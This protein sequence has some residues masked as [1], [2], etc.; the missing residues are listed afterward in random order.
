MGAPVYVGND[1]DGND[2]WSSH[3]ETLIQWLCDGYRARFNQH[4][5]QRK[6]TVWTDDPNSPGTRIPLRDADGEKVLAP[7]GDTEP[8]AKL[9]DTE[10]RETF[11]F[12]A[13]LPMQVLQHPERV[14]NTE[15]WSVIKRR[16]TLAA[17]RIPAGAMP[18]FRSR[19][20]GDCRFGVWFNG[21]KNAVA[22]RV[23]RSSGVLVITGMNPADKR[24]GKPARWSLRI[25]FRQTA[26]LRAYTSVEV[27]WATKRLVFISPPPE[28]EHASTGKLVG[29][30]RGVANAV[31]TSSG[32]L[33]QMPDTAGAERARKRHQQAMARSN[34]VAEAEGR[35]WRASNRR[36]RHRGLA[37]KHSRR[38]ANVR[39]EFVEQTSHRLIRDH[40]LVALEALDVRAMTRAPKPVPDPNKPGAWLSNGAAAKRGLNR[41]I[42][43]SGWTMLAERLRQ[44]G[45]QAGVPVVF[46]DPKH[47][48]Q[49]CSECGHIA[50]ENRE[51]QAIFRCVACG[52][53]E[54]ADINAARNILARATTGWTSP[55]GRRSQSGVGDADTAISREPRTPAL[56]SGPTGIPRL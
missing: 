20:R 30:D 17:K 54:H 7:L 38:I 52:Y 9:R 51:S 55:A 16:R 15:W 46:V 50:P 27:N 1:A 40:D 48:S 34:R 31:V 47:T 41:G 11:P 26:E 33:I 35:D 44:K 53:T 5:A 56:A 28:R 3:P 39:K 24:Q 14:E 13:A 10:A 23:S 18:R 19:K 32:D 43:A 42:L 12:L 4:R 6:K 21:G 49:R 37:A 8:P 29:V 36:K 25:T 45:K 2:Q 22:N